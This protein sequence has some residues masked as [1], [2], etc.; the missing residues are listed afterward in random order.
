MGVLS[1]ILGTMGQTIRSVTVGADVER[2]AWNLAMCLPEDALPELTRL[3]A[4]YR[5]PRQVIGL[6]IRAII[7]ARQ[8]SDACEQLLAEL[9]NY[10]EETRYSCLISL[11]P[12]LPPHRLEE[13]LGLCRAIEDEVDCLRFLTARI[14]KG[15]SSER[16]DRLIKQILATG[17]AHQASAF[18]DLLQALPREARTSVESLAIES[19]SKL[20]APQPRLQAIVRL[21]PLAEHGRDRLLADAISLSRSFPADQTESQITALAALIPLCSAAQTSD[22]VD[23][24]ITCL[25]RLP[26]DWKHRPL[27][28]QWVRFTSAAQRARILQDANRTQSPKGRLEVLGSLL[29]EITEPKRTELAEQALELCEQSPAGDFAIH[30]KNVLNVLP[31]RLLSRA[32]VL[33]LRMSQ[34]RSNTGLDV[35]GRSWLLKLLEL[36][37]NPAQRLKLARELIRICQRRRQPESSI[38]AELL[39]YLPNPSDEQRTVVSLI[40]HDIQQERA[41]TPIPR[42]IDMTNVA[43]F[44]N[45]EQ[46]RVAFFSFMERHRENPFNLQG[47]QG[48]LSKLPVDLLP[49]AG[50]FA[51][52]CTRHSM[53][54]DLFVGLSKRLSELSASAQS[55]L[56]DR[57]LTTCATSNRCDLLRALNNIWPILETLGPPELADQTM[58][59]LFDA[60]AAFHDYEE[61]I[62]SAMSKRERKLSESL[63]CQEMPNSKQ[64]PSE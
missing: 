9:P 44:L 28:H 26:G 49:A 63:M 13:A 35:F 60:Q 10:D 23:E 16:L 29:P 61:P 40:L 21:I 25:S 52:V 1:E 54:R 39:P 33:A 45:E 24:L 6:R 56:L 4:G 57:L 53:A 64:I 50:D 34:D 7:L 37:T 27:Y 12:K 5:W 31:K 62:S 14:E 42:L 11:A 38:L 58:D 22:L 17:P 55:S 30:F 48:L 36:C 2:L 51:I 18:A 32:R 59:A 15:I 8:G 46:V 19:A 3:T 43:P 47:I 41:F 20:A